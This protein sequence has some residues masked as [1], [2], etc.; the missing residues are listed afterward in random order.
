MDMRRECEVMACAIV[1]G[2]SVMVAA[3]SEGDSPRAPVVPPG[4]KRTARGISGGAMQYWPNREDRAEVV[5]AS[6]VGGKGN[7]WLVDAGFQADGSLVLAGNAI[8]GDFELCVPIRTL[9][10][11]HSKPPPYAPK[12]MVDRQTKA[13]VV[14]QLGQQRY[15]KVSWTDAGVTGF[16]VKLDAGM[17]K[18]VSASRLGWGS[19][20][21]TACEVASDGS[22]YIAGRAEDGAAGLSGDSDKAIAVADEEAKGA[23][24]R[25]T[26]V[27]KL[28]A[29]LGKVLWVRVVSGPAF[30]PRLALKRDGSVVASLADLRT[31]DAGGKLLSSVV[32]PGGLGMRN[33]VSPLNGE[34]VR[35]GEHNW[36]TGREPWRCPILNILY[37][38]GRLRY[39]FMDWGG[40][41]VGLDN[42]RLVS[43]TAVRR[44]S[45]DRNGNIVVVLWSD[46][47]NSVGHCQ[48]TDVRRGVGSRGCGLTT[49]G[50][51]ATSFAYL[52][53][54]EPGDYQVTGW[55]LWCSQY[56][57]K[58]N[59]A[60]ISRTAQADD[61]STCFAGGSAWGLRQTPNCLSSTE[62][63]GSYVAVLTADLTGV[64]YSSIVPG[65][66]MAE[67]GDSSEW[68]IHT[69]SPNGRGR[70][71]FLCGAGKDGDN[72]GLVTPTPAVNPLQKGFGGGICDGW[73]L[74]LDIPKSIPPAAVPTVS[75]SRMTYRSAARP[76]GAKP[77]RNDAA[78]ADGTVYE[79]SPT[80]PKWVTVDAEFRH[81]DPAKFW[82][83]FFYGRPVAGKIVWNVNSPSGSFVVQCDRLVDP[84]G[85][86]DRRI[87]GE[88]IK[89]DAAPTVTLSVESLG[90]WRK[91]SFEQTD[92]GGRSSQLEVS[93]WRGEATLQIGDKTVKI[94]PAITLK[95]SA[96]VEKSL[97]AINVSVW[98][99]L[100]GKDLGMTGRAKNEQIDVRIS[101]QGMP[102]GVAAAAEAARKN[103]KR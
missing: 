79:F 31:Y 32:V 7:E 81:G 25:Q 6:F 24:C 65:A 43:D 86:Q 53:R 8:G 29:D 45:H 51:G 50:A 62:P 16:V 37:P 60:G 97:S 67:V 5:A 39:Q 55:T 30:A 64:R 75:P 78:A 1:V 41:Y 42:C 68:G 59:G 27:A 48:P 93:Y 26:F 13:P 20:A 49:A 71:V 44:V 56:G 15:E 69:G 99:T 95:P 52:M 3:A 23:S 22:V 92:A 72:Y 46:G 90:Q 85:E 17:T 84:R 21:I 101:A 28:S 35:G 83:N 76:V 63:G 19:G 94:E 66:G 61:G 87:L 57:G 36:G 100:T 38:D 18:I 4:Q 98:F 9:G 73:F 40:P 2:A 82:P 47:G 96:V 58:A 91:E 80:F 14:D 77:G 89:P 54:I 33:S 34:V 12:P 88:L 10:T 70:A 11:D 74:V 103:K 102:A